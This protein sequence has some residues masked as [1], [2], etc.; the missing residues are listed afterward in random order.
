M[1]PPD[2]GS[3]SPASKS[4]LLEVI[5]PQGAVVEGPVA[6]PAPIDS[7]TDFVATPDGDVIW[8]YSRGGAGVDFTR[9]RGC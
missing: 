1:L 8:A 3:S 2:P 5:D 7:F 6:V 9:V 4:L